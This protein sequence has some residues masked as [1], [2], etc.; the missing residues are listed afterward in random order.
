MCCLVSI[1]FSIWATGVIICLVDVKCF[2]F[3]FN[4]P[5]IGHVI[6][7]ASKCNFYRCTSTVCVERRVV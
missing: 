4:K 7:L 1:A 2:G 5:N 3:F 6:F